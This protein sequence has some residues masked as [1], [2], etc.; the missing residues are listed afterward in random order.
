MSGFKNVNWAALIAELLQL[1]PQAI[2][3]VEQDKSTFGSEAKTQAAA[4]AT[5]QA[6]QIAQTIDP[7][8]TETINAA[9]AV[10]EGIVTALKTPPPTQSGG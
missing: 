3:D 1:A 10:T 5:M 4:Q 6:S 2:V 8:D 9:T 7:N